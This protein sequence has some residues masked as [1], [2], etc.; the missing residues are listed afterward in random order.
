[1]FVCAEISCYGSCLKWVR[2]P[3]CRLLRCSGFIFFDIQSVPYVVDIAV[4][5]DFV[6]PCQQKRS[7]QHA[8]YSQWL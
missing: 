7:Y 2:H 1:M 3:Y 4:G 6:G 8:S 5:D